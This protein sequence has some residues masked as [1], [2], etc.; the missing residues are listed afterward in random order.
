MKNSTKRS[1][2]I[3]SIATLILTI[4]LIAM[5]FSEEVNWDLRDYLIMGILLFSTASVINVIL[6]KKI[7]FKT[8]IIYVAVAIF[9]LFLIWAELA[10]GIFGSPF[11]GN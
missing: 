10:M 5:Q 4:P 11:A 2:T 8:K 1:I 6:K 9:V 7:A 3:Y